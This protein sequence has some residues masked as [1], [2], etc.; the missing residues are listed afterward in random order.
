ME[1]IKDHIGG[2]KTKRPR[3]P[4]NNLNRVA[5][6]IENNWWKMLFSAPF[7][8]IRSNVNKISRI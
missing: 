6:S 3:G 5:N 4:I 7:T 8:D 1:N 2:Y